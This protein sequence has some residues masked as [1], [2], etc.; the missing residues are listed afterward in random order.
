LFVASRRRV[1][2]WVSVFVVAALVLGAAFVPIGQASVAGPRTNATFST[3]RIGSLQEPDSLN[4]NVGV[5]TAAY[6]VW[7]HVYELLVGI[8]PDL[9]PVPSLAQSWSHSADNLTWTFHLVQNATWHDGQPFTAEDVNFTFRMIA[10]ASTWNPVGCDLTLLQGYLGAVDVGNITVVDPYTI[11]I[12]TF[13]PKANILSMFIQILPK[14][15]WSALNCAQAGKGQNRPPIGTGM[16]KW[17]AYHRGAYTQLDLYPQYWRLDPTQDYV[18]QIIIIYYKDST[19]LYN[20]FVSGAI[21][22]TSALTTNQF[23]QVPD[24]VQGSAVTNVYHYTYSQISFAETGMCVASDQLIADWGAGGGRSWLVANLTVRQAL[25]LS[26]NRSFLVQNIIAGLGTPGTTTIPPAT[27]FWHY[28]V[29]PAEAYPFDPSRA[30][31]LLD[32]PKGDGAALKAGQ[33]TPGDFGENLDPAAANN[34]DAFIDT[35][36]DHIRDVVNPSQVVAGDE[37]GPAAPNRPDLS[38][39]IQVIDYDVEGSDAADRMIQWW[40]DVGIGVTKRIVTESVQISTTYD[41]SED[42]YIWGWGGDVDPDFLL[43]IMTTDQILYW[44]DAWY[45]NGTYDQLYLDQQTQVDPAVRQATIFEMQK[46]LYHDAPYLVMYYPF[47]LAVVRTDKFSGWGDWAAHPGLGLTGYGNDF[48]ML[49]LRAGAAPANNC[50]IKPVIE[51]AATLTAFANETKTFAATSGDADADN[52][53]W[54]WSWDDGNT[55]QI[56]TTANVNST[57]TQY[58]WE[59]PGLYNMTVTVDD[60]K[61]SPVTSDP[62]AVQILP[63]PAALGYIAGTVRD[64]STSVILVGATVAISPGGY[65]ATTD[66]AG[67]FNVTLPPGTY[68]ATASRDLYGSQTRTGL[69][70]TANNTT[71]AQFQLTPVRGWIAGTITSSTGGALAGVAVQAV[72]ARTYGATTDASG[73]YNVTIAPGTYA[74]TARLSGYANQT[75]S[76][77]T[78]T[79]GATTTVNFVL[80]STVLPAG[81]DVL[82]VAGIGIGVLVLILAIVAFVVLRKRRKEEEIQGPPMPPQPP[83]PPV[84]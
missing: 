82:L 54:I 36:G 43:S 8:G 65:G 24:K 30:R 59:T 83:P 63:R 41:C 52:L 70:V 55:T 6:T 75:Q 26:V 27:E 77:I 7:A 20:A 73:R 31:A 60:N 80:T 61:C 9:T 81:P 71:S 40:A 58:A 67:T 39:T 38:L 68:S 18:D 45:S 78:V 37:H 62:T 10:P 13:S 66:S 5:L 69:V 64:A 79:D 1:A 57:V 32:D 25:Q 35:N 56:N 29:T 48:V 22:A 49:T 47:A 50:P 14:H 33:T 19:S 16:Y 51:G 44:Q 21:D 15:I 4:P 46:V 42:M 11:R 23:I 3:L 17:T 2:A 76:G 74:V 28:N 12:P 53:V 34:Q 84:P 72:G